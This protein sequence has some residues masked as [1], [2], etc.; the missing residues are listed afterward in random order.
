[1]SDLGR[2]LAQNP[3]PH[4][5][6]Q[7]FA[8]AAEAWFWTIRTLAARRDG[9]GGGSAVP[10][11]GDPDDIIK[12]LDRLFQRG[13]ISV[14]QVRIMRRWGERGFAPDARCPAETAAA[15]LWR[16]AMRAMSGPLAL[17]GIVGDTRTL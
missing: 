10:R 17:R 15:R 13:R 12:C 16:D 4:R 1:M 14:A 9:T 3:C 8:D 5:R 6:A 7:P 2:R 11:P